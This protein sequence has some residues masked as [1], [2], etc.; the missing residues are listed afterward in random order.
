MR[1]SAPSGKAGEDAGFLLKFSLFQLPIGTQLLFQIMLMIPVGGLII[2][3]MRQIIGVR[4]FGTFMPVLVALSFRETGLIAG[5]FSF[6]LIVILGLIIRSWFHR[7][8][9]LMVP[10]LAAVLT[11]VVLLICF[12]AL[13]AQNLGLTLGLSLSLFPIVILTMT[14]ERMSTTWDEYGPREATMI[15][16]GSLF[17]AMIAFFVLT[18]QLLTHLFFTFPELLLVVLALNICMG[19]YNGFK[20]TE[21]GR[22]KALQRQ[23]AQRTQP[24]DEPK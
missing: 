7:L 5:V 8:Q 2:A 4:T 13:L 18:N 16:L 19:R 6:T 22:F 1:C 12:M 24:S 23:I 3:F 14:I 17:S 10:R 9:L 21:Y 15:G 11:I 20:L